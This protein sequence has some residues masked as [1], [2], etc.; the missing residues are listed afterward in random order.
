M[1]LTHKLT[2]DIRD[3]SKNFVIGG[4]QIERARNV[5]NDRGVKTLSP[6][7]Y[8]L[9]ARYM[10]FSAHDWIILFISVRK[11]F[12]SAERADIK[13]AFDKLILHPLLRIFTSEGNKK[14][15]DDTTC[16]GKHYR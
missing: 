4:E 16:V 15:V 6:M 12:F 2:G 13:L 7:N 14:T 9:R 5:K 3:P 8:G 10:R 1:A 11:L